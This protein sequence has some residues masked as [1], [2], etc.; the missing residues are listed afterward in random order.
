MRQPGR[1]ARQHRPAGRRDRAPDCRARH[2]RQGRGALQARRLP[3]QRARTPGPG[4][5]QGPRA[6]RTPQPRF[7]QS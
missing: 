4:V 6:G 7:R 5:R 1:R 2:V 3:G